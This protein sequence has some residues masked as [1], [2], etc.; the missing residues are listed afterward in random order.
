MNNKAELK[1]I[2]LRLLDRD[3]IDDDAEFIRCG[4]DSMFFGRL[5]IEIKRS[6]GKRIPIAKI[7]ANGTLNGVYGLLD[8]EAQK[9]LNSQ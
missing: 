4:G 3:D 8:D 2:I 6:F 7:F 5:Q 1:A 9:K